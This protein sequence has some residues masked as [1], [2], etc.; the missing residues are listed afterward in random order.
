MKTSG[1]MR[2]AYC[3]LQ[4]LREQSGTDHGFISNRHRLEAMYLCQ[5]T[6]QF[7]GGFFGIVTPLQAKPKAVVANNKGASLTDPLRYT[8][9]IMA[10][11]LHYQR[12]Y[13]SP[14]AFG[15]TFI[16][17]KLIEPNLR[18]PSFL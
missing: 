16:S 15:F 13:S 5:H 1:A 3:T 6:R 9:L 4:N 18:M 8:R 10:G 12:S 7:F 11:L 17:I 2:Y 14:V